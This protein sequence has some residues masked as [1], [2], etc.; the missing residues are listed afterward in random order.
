[1]DE[2]TVEAGGEGVEN[3]AFVILSET[4]VFKGGVGGGGGGG[5][6]GRSDVAVAGAGRGVV[7]NVVLELVPDDEVSGAGRGVADDGLSL[8][9]IWDLLS[10]VCGKC[11]G[12]EDEK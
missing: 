4:G 3:E 12:H 1:M 6:G 11:A 5:D 8:S 7:D 9:C 10:L 2:M